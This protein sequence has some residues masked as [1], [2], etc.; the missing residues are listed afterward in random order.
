LTIIDSTITGNLTANG[1]I[2]V[3]RSDVSGNITTPNNALTIIDSTI[4]GNLTANGDI[5]VT[6]SDVSGNITTP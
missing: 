4:T 6:R 5:I 1:D 3:T 2:I